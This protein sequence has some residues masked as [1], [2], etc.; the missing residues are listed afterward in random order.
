MD[1]RRYDAGMVLVT[2]LVILLILTMLALSAVQST[3]I[4]ELIAR[5]QRDSNLAF[6]AAETALVEAEAVLNEMTSLSYGA[7]NDNDP[8]IYDARLSGSF[9]S[10]TDDPWDSDYVNALQVFD[11]A[12]T[13]QATPGYV[14]EHLQT[15]VSD[16][17]RLNIDNIGQNPNTCCT[18]M[19]R[20][21]ARGSG[22]TAAAVVVLQ[23]TYG[24]R[25]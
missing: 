18:Q 22:G 5:N 25:F 16:E 24:K 15:I 2:S 13:L 20:V 21:T 1:L 11:P 17:D 7:S 9:F 3:S 8:K 23:S 4:Q 14:I 19:F 6:N 10:V 12:T